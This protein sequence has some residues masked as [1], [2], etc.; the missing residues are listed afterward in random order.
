[1]PAGVDRLLAWFASLLP[2][3]A[4]ARTVPV[5]GCVSGRPSNRSPAM[6][7]NRPRLDGLPFHLRLNQLLH[8]LLITVVIGARVEL[9]VRCLMIAPAITTISASRS[10]SA[11]PNC[12]GRTSPAARNVNSANPVPRGSTETIRS[13]GLR[14]RRPTPT[15]P[16]WAI[17]G[18]ITGSASTAIGPSG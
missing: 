12:G 8:R 17:A 3:F 4:P 15:T 13:R 16:A 18:P 9:P 6:A 5:Q 2:F 11:L 14:V 10:P 7:L 1:M